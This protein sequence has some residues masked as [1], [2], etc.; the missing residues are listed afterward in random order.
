MLADVTRQ[1]HRLPP[2][3]GHTKHREALATSL[4][5]PHISSDAISYIPTYYT[6]Q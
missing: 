3:C 6:G 1:R 2:V 4:A 5:S